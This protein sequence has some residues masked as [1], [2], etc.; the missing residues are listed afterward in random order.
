MSSLQR[1]MLVVALATSGVCAQGTGPSKEQVLQA[2]RECARYA[3]EVLIDE[4]GKSRCD[5]SLLDGKWYDYEPPWHTGQLINGLVEAYKVTKGETYLAVAK[6]AGDWWI[7]LE[8]KDHPKLKGM[9]RAIHGDGIDYI[10]CATVT[11][12][13]PGLFNLYRVT[14]EGSML[15]FR[16]AR[17][18]GC[19]R[20]STSRKKG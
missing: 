17:G 14:K 15:M 1:A 16:P 10:V 8:I 11:D 18:N 12:G 6:K 4:N 2:I 3:T 20:T 13:T 9:V 19:C 7:G 5:Y